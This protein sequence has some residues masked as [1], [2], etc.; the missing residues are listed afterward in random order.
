M[1]QV[2]GLHMPQVCSARIPTFLNRAYFTTVQ[3]LQNIG[4]TFESKW[5]L[6]VSPLSR[7]SS[8]LNR[9]AC[10]VCISLTLHLATVLKMERSGFNLHNQSWPIKDGLSP[11]TTSTLSCD[12]W[13]LQQTLTEFLSQNN[14]L[15]TSAGPQHGLP[16]DGHGYTGQYQ[17]PSP[18]ENHL[19]V[20]NLSGPPGGLC[21]AKW[22]NAIVFLP[23][24]GF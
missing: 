23:N 3:C 17:S 1:E 13:P 20:L 9:K 7:P 11:S 4:C 5:N 15:L 14:Q 8:S 22:V 12:A 24:L 10:W 19:Q 18:V 16:Y 6:T 21:R 2:T